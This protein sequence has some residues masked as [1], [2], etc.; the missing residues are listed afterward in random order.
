MRTSL[1][2]VVAATLAITAIFSSPS[3]ASTPNTWHVQ[4]GSVSFDASGPSAGGNRFYPEALSIHAGDS[5]LFTPIGPHTVTFNRPPGPL[6]FLFG[7]IGGSPSAGTIGS[8]SAP[9]SSGFIGGAPG[10]TYRLTFASTLAAG[11]YTVIC[12]LHLGMTE[13]IDLL[14]STQALPKTDAQY[15]AL[16]QKEIARD[17]AHAADI[18][19]AATEN[20]QKEDDNQLVLVGAGNARVSNIR[21]F[22]AAVTI[23]VGESVTFLKTHDPTEP[24]T[25]TFGTEPPD[26]LGQLMARGGSTYS[27]TENLSSGFMSTAAQFAYFQL[28][29]LPLPVALTKY[30]LTFTKAGDFAYFCALHDGAGM[31]GV[32]HVVP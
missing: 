7:P 8:P 26:P 5:V 11:R 21:F 22:P 10:D 29:G 25:V 15:T 27:G 28:A 9:V 2:S 18:A 12:G 1:A 32:V 31:R 20:D 14:P 13:T 30:R 16:A 4:A 17:L 23:H 3:F 19:K 6:F 24:H